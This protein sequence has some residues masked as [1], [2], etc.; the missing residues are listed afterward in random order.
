MGILDSVFGGSGRN[1][2]LMQIARATE[3]AKIRAAQEKRDREIYN[4]QKRRQDAN[5]KKVDAQYAEQKRIA[6]EAATASTEAEAKRQGDIR[7]G[8][9]N[10]D[11]AF[12]QFDDNWYNNLMSSY[13]DL[14]NPSIDTEA[15]KAKDTLTAALAGRGILESSVGAAKLAEAEEKRIAARTQIGNDALT[16]ADSVKNKLA[17]TKN[18]LYDVNSSSADPEGV[19]ARAIGEA[20]NLASSAATQFQSPSQSGD[21]SV[22][23]PLSSVSSIFGDLATPFIAGLQAQSNRAKNTNTGVKATGLSSGGS[24]RIV[25]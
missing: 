4:E 9:G 16:Y 22:S 11:A 18:S 19:K 15:A 13:T 10:I 21:F 23:T 25:S 7:T 5:Q 17:G 24:A 8:M 3:E 6:A 2:R 20:T 14:Y 1:E 12:G